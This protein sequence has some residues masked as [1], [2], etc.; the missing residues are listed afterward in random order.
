VPRKIRSVELRAY[1]PGESTAHTTF[2]DEALIEVSVTETAQDALGS[3]S[4]ELD[5]T[6][7]G[8]NTPRITSG[9]RL[10][11]D[12]QLAAESSR[13]RYWTAIARDVTSSLQGG[14]T[15]RIEVN[16]TDFPFTVLA[17]RNGDAGFD[18]VDA[19]NVLDSLVADNAPKIGRSQIQTVGVDVT[20]EVAGQNLLNVL[21]QQLAPLGDAVV[22]ADGTDLVF[23]SLNEVNVKHRLTPADLLAP[24]GIQRVDDE[25][26]NRVRVD[27]GNDHKIDDEQL[28]Q[29]SKKRVTDSTRL[30]TQIETR[31]SEVARVQVFTDPDPNSQDNV[32]VRLQAARNGS[33]VDVSDRESDI[34]RR[35]LAP[36]FL[37]END[38]TEFQ[39][40][41]HRLPPDQKPFLIIE[42]SGP[43]GQPIG[44]DGSGTPTFKSEFPYPLVSFAEN[45]DSQRRFRRRDLREKDQTLQTEE[46]VKDRATATLKHQAEPKRRVAASAKSAR[47]H[48]LQPADAVRLEEFP[49]PGVSGTFLTVSRSSELSENLLRTDLT[50]TDATTI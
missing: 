33:P 28:T 8:L 40:P 23:K 16:A 22:A 20:I 27:G 47:A 14:D 4:I 48:R 5:T 34:A 41:A 45:S 12:V 18:G 17:F 13:S 3:G 35:V 19:G 42:A 30:T 11:L 21:S 39:M 24:I 15:S 1:R 46:A 6:D 32:I 2:T 37:S 29:S 36:A 50:L 38:F 43:D 49:V 10:E 44:T 7:R 25:L 26:I 9:D 31:K